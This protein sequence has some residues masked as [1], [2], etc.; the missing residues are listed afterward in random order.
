MWGSEVWD[1]KGLVKYGDFV[2]ADVRRAYEPWEDWELEILRK[3]Y[4]KMPASRIGLILGRSSRAI[5]QKAKAL[6][7]KSSNFGSYPKFLKLLPS[8]CRWG[9]KR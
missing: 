9:G 1:D 7:L 4:G 6:G 8:S 3:Y 5:R 2:R